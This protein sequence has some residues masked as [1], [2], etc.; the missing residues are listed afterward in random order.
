MPPGYQQSMPPG[1]QQPGYQPP[2][3]QQPY[4]MQPPH[5]PPP[6]GQPA[7]AQ[8][9]PADPSAMRNLYRVALVVSILSTIAF[10]VYVFTP[11]ATAAQQSHAHPYF[12]AGLIGLAISEVC[13]LLGILVLIGHWASH[14]NTEKRLREIL[15]LIASLF[16]GVIIVVFL[17]TL[18]VYLRARR[19][20]PA[21]EQT[22]QAKEDLKDKPLDTIVDLSANK[23]QSLAAG[24]A[25]QPPA[26]PAG[27]ATRPTLRDTVRRVIGPSTERSVSEVG[28]G[29]VTF[30]MIALVLA[31]IATLGAV[32]PVKNLVSKQASVSS[33]GGGG[34]SSHANG[35]PGVVKE[36][37]LPSSANIPGGIT[38]GPDGNL[39]LT[40]P[41][42]SGSQAFDCN[43]S[44]ILRVTP[45]GQTTQ[46]PISS[47]GDPEGIAV[48]PDGNLWFGL[49]RVN[50]AGSIASITPSGTITEYPLHNFD[51]ATSI[52]AGPDGA[53][54]FTESVANRIGRITTSGQ[55]TFFP[56]SSNDFDPSGITAGPDGNLWYTVATNGGGANIGRITPGGVITEYS[57]PNSQT[58]I[59]S[60][61]NRTLEIAKGADGKLWFTDGN[62]IGSTTTD[63]QITAYPLPDSTNQS[64][65]I[66]TG[67]DGDA[68]FTACTP[69]N[70]A[71][72]SC[73]HI[74]IGR[75]GSGG[76]ITMYPIPIGGAVP[77]EITTGPDK[78]L[79]FTE[80]FS[81]VM[82][83]MTS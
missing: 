7:T 76:Q 36:I 10:V 9:R 72:G 70:G 15:I 14:F 37:S 26:P 81:N 4:M 48:G 71:N 2:G 44:A 29:L 1:Y 78:N 83:Y 19:K 43:G 62:A 46:F 18:I 13:Q 54:W 40:S 11:R 31:V 25:Q 58:A 61:G 41:C 60:F 16:P 63:G 67:P 51:E 59:A 82:G 57:I 28:G 5:A 24:V 32:T 68:W 22:K 66:T 50:A 27:R 75:V 69:F 64:L 47:T 55:A 23:S 56:L 73:I 52:T 65:S 79:W 77:A 21:S 6:P 8:K 45:S 30:T 34:S 80:P 17:W 39:W 53:L 74:G 3:Y 38:T 35:H 20:D 42:G 12:L 49:A 33:G